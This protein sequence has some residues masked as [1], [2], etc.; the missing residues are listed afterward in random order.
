VEVPGHGKQKIN[1][2]FA[3]G[4]PELVRKTILQN[5]DLD[6]NYYA[7]VDFQGFPKI[8]DIVAPNGIDVDIPNEMKYGIGMTLHPGKQTLHGDELL[9]YVR[10]RHDSKS[11]FGR[12][13]RQQEVLSKAKEQA[14]S[15][16]SL[17]NL[18]KLLGIADPY[19]DTNIDKRTILSIGKGLLIGKGQQ[20]ETLRI[21]VKD[22]FKDERVNVG[23][24][25]SIDFDKNKQ[26][27]HEFLS[28]DGES[29]TETDLVFP[30]E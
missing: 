15:V 10:F 9:G 22:S 5:F 11:D 18:P 24:V 7:V 26:A 4:G 25:L 29:A 3:F 6:I 28:G 12:V 14:I 2:A 27:L 13:E 8:I 17:V 19:I 21:P 20:M 30:K 23:S 16:H 1:A